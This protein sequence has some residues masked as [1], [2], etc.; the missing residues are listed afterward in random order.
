MK[1]HNIC[2]HG[3][4]KS[5]ICYRCC[6]IQLYLVVR[7]YEYKLPKFINEIIKLFWGKY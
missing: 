3:H 4:C 2:G 5:D 6:H 1:L 7:K